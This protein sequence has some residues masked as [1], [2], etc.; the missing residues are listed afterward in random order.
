MGAG[1]V[2]VGSETASA[3]F[4]EFF[5]EVEPRLRR[6]LIAAVGIEAGRDAA[7]EELAYGWEHRD[8]IGSMQN[9]AGYLYRVGRS[10]ARRRTAARPGVFLPARVADEPWCE[11]GLRAALEG[12]SERQRV[13]VMLVHGFGYTT[14]EAG[15]LLGLR[16]GTVQ[17]RRLRNT[18]VG[19]A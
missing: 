15:D 1:I 13:A 17:C 19:I 4:T 2:A 18:G 3:T 6:A 14:G 8:R 10:R 9:P 11:P 5:R 12:L 7:A 16:G